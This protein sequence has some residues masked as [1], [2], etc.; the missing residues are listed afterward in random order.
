MRREVDIRI[1]GREVGDEIRSLS[2]TGLV[3]VLG[4]F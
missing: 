4:R 3:H 1:R 2:R